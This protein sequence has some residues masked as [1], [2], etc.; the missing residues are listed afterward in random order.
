M[1][2]PNTEPVVVA[3]PAVEPEVA[4]TERAEIY[5]PANRPRKVYGGMWG[6]LEVGAVS[7]AGL[8]VLLAGVLYFF[9]VVPS[10]RELARN[11]SEAERLDAELIS[12]KSKYGEITDTQAEVEKIVASVDDFEAR[13]LPLPSTGQTALYQRVNGLLAAYGLTNTTGPDYAPLETA[14]QAPGQQSEEEKGRS[15]YRSLYPGVYVSTT[16]EGS[17]QN[18]RRFIRE[19]ETGREF[20]IVSAV[21]LAPSDT[22]T[23]KPRPERQ[24]PN[25]PFDPAKAQNFGQGGFGGAQ[26]QAQPQVRARPKGKTHGETVSLHIEM[27]AYF[28]RPNFAP[29]VQ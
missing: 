1:T 22:E 7:V 14:E 6:P 18:L 19:I 28:R 24:D 11:K 13:F 10:D 5:V 23:R 9:W 27:A 3:R 12:A 25:A 16:V 4:V 2:D 20:I 29:A 21:E 17:Y 26:M 8:V 15:K